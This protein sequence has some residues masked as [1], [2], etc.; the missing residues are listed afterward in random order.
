MMMVI[1]VIDVVLWEDFGF[2]YIMWV[3]FG[4]RGVYVWVCD[5]KV[6]LMDD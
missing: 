4:R 2:K 6:R 3:Y 1:K 5:K